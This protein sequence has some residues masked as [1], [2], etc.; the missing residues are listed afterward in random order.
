MSLIPNHD[1][2][3]AQL[4]RLEASQSALPWPERRLL[5]AS[6]HTALLA[7]DDR[8]VPLRLVQVLAD[9][10]KWEVRKEIAALLPHLPDAE[11]APIAAKLTEDSNAF[12]RTSAQR[13]FDRRRRGQSL[14]GRRGAGIPDLA[15]EIELL[16]ATHGR[17][18]ARKVRGMS[19]RLYNFMAGAAV[20]EIRAI[21]TPLKAAAIRLRT[22]VGRGELDSKTFA[23]GLSQR[24]DLLERFVDQMK[25]YSEVVPIERTPERLDEVIDE[26]C[27][28]ACE[29]LKYAGDEVEHIHL[30]VSVD[31]QATFPMARLYIMGAL[32]N[33]IR[34]AYDALLADE[35]SNRTNHITIAAKWRAGGDLLIVIADDGIGIN[36]DD[37]SELLAFVPG[38]ISKKGNGTGFGLPIAR[39]YVEAH[40]GDLLIESAEGEGTTVT[41]RLPAID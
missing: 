5:A 2:L 19:D 32:R 37:L 4:A 38:R 39:R 11:F 3:A 25:A 20:H 35:T 16:E 9:D 7:T 15:A 1:E 26:A 30:T 18:V 21:L 12:V 13:S 34:N 22:D 36:A 17:Q 23:D 28:L 10:P 40:G 24:L 29:P 31:S 8:A 27:R 33:V 41:M 6:L 14:A